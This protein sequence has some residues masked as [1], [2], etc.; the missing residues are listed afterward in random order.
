MMN[1]S[2]AAITSQWVIRIA[3]TMPFSCSD[4]IKAY[5]GVSLSSS[6][7]KPHLGVINTGSIVSFMLVHVKM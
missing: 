6:F 4:I 2:H 3:D 7:I 1:L 5:V